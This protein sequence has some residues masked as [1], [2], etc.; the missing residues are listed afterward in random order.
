MSKEKKTN[1]EKKEGRA[2]K[3][4]KGQEVL[5]SELLLCTSTGPGRLLWVQTG[6]CQLGSGHLTFASFSLA[7]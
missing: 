2:G 1:E 6:P 3:S 5:A 4:G 7:N